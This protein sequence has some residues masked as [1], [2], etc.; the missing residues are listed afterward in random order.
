MEIVYVFFAAKRY[1]PDE[2]RLQE[3]YRSLA[4]KICVNGKTVLL[5]EDES[6]SKLPEGDCLA[7]VPMSGA[8]QRNILAAAEKYSCCVIYAA[9]IRGNAPDP[10]A[11]EMLRCNAAPTVMDAWAVLRRKSSRTMLAVSKKELHRALKVFGA[12]HHVRNS[13]LLLIGDTEPWVISNCSDHRIYENRFGLKLEQIP[14][15]EVAECY[16]ST[17]EEEGRSYY[18]HF[19]DGSQNSI[20]PTGKDLQNAARMAAAL[21]KTLE[22]HQAD[23]CALACFNLLQ[24]GTNSCLGVSF[25]NEC[26]DMAAACEG[27]L[28]SAV[29]MLMMKKLAATHLWMA[30]PGLQPDGTIHFSHCTAPL[31]IDGSDGLPCILRSHHESGIGVSLQVEFPVERTVTAC[32]ISDDASKITIHRGVSVQGPY[33]CACRTQMYVRLEE[34]DHYLHTALGCHQVLA[35]EDITW[36]MRA[37]AGMFGLEIL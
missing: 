5:T 16:H 23:G 19:K 13:R 7:A 32:R 8:V 31:S 20:E 26:T 25:V 6:L 33:E 35:F 4:D 37:L 3:A 34:M 30:N 36:E 29:T 14:Q 24:E 21:V 9:Y 28:D 15:S 12:Y 17:T 2:S 1:W 10:L 22:K 18:E 27:D 11:Q